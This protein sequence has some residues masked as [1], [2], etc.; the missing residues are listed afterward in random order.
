MRTVRKLYIFFKP[1]YKIWKYI[2]FFHTVI[3]PNYKGRTLKVGKNCWEK[4]YFTK[5]NKQTFID[6]LE[7]FPCSAA[8]LLS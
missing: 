5:S 3:L 2:M 8:G 6:S 4:N 1:P 7:L